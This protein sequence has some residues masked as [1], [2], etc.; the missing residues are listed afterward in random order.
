VGCEAANFALSVAGIARTLY[1][2]EGNPEWKNC[3]KATFEPYFDKT[4]IISKYVSDVSSDTAVTLDDYFHDKELNF[5]KMDVEGFERRCLAG[6]KELLKRDN[7]RWAVCV[8]HRLD[9]A[10]VIGRIFTD[11]GYKTEFTPGWML[12]RP[13][14][15]IVDGERHILRGQRPKPRRVVIRAWK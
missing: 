8:Y 1:L 10:E 2:F 14:R 7:V 9:D 5:I 15:E 12:L 6:A 4:N 13:Q 3:L 11:A